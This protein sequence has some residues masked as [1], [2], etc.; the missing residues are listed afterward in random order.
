MFGSISSFSLVKLLTTQ[1]YIQ[2]VSNLI[3]LILGILGYIVKFK[4]D[5]D[6]PTVFAI[7]AI[8]LMIL[9]TASSSIIDFINVEEEDNKHRLENIK[10]SVEAITTVLQI[11]LQNDN[12]RLTKENLSRSDSLI[13]YSNLTYRNVLNLETSANNINSNMK[14]SIDRQINLLNEQ[15]WL[16]Y[17]TLRLSYPLE[18]LEIFYEVEYSF[19]RP[20]LGQY[21]SI[22]QESIMKEINSKRKYYNQIKNLL[23]YKD[24]NLTKDY[25][26]YL[27]QNKQDEAI[28]RQL[29]FS[30]DME[31]HI[32]DKNGLEII[33]L[34]TVDDKFELISFPESVE[35]QVYVNFAKRTFT[36]F[37]HSKKPKRIGNDN[38]AISSIDLIDRKIKWSFRTLLISKLNRIGF[39]FKYDLYN[40]DFNR[41]IE[42]DENSDILSKRNVFIQSKDIGV[43]N[44]LSSIKSR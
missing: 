8:I 42:I 44:V 7:V 24:I 30:N 33:I 19:D 27:P 5:K 9:S 43:E 20:I 35:F 2:L 18:P 28:I 25:S 23:D 29:F 26:T 4:D 14:V 32:I 38:L 13:F 36:K 1:F 34:P 22:L 21:A 17:Q 12:L 15:E 3:L 41:F 39:K 40:S 10:Q 6:K 16:Q 37:V 31:L 11:K